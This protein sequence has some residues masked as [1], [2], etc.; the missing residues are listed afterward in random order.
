M[1]LL[2]SKRVVNGQTEADF[3]PEGD[4]TRAEFVS[5]IV[6]GLGLEEDSTS[7][8]P[9]FADIAETNWFAGAI[10]AA[11]KAQI[12]SG[13]ED[14]TFWPNDTITREQMAVMLSNALAFADKPF[15][16]TG[17]LLPLLAVFHDKTAI[18]PRAQVATVQ[19]RNPV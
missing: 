12:V 5:L 10:G 15:A 11:V 3:V 13:F 2:A 7:V 9:A 17:K 16:V 4:V 19:W 6:R 1:E 14:G 18:S 8:H